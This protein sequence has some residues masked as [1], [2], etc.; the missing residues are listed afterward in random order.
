[1]KTIEQ[2]VNRYEYP[3]T[4]DSILDAY[5]DMDDMVAEAIQ[6]LLSL[7]VEAIL[8]ETEYLDDPI[9]DDRKLEVAL[10]VKDVVK[11]L[12]SSE[13]WGYASLPSELRLATASSAAEKWLSAMEKKSAGKPQKQKKCGSPDKDLLKAAKKAYATLDKKDEL[14][15]EQEKEEKRKKQRREAV[16][17]Y[18]AK[19]KAEK[20]TVVSVVPDKNGKAVIVQGG[21]G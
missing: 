20:A 17:R 11:A 13:W 10:S 19:K 1:M 21:E 7:K 15:A 4:P 12:R 16:Q 2:L 6:D 5:A 18:R 8:E 14:S 3:L 9:P